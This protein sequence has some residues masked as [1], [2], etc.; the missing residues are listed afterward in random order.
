VHLSKKSILDFIKATKKSKR[1]AVT[2]QRWNGSR[3]LA[4]IFESEI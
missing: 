4:K 2:V 3:A 1:P